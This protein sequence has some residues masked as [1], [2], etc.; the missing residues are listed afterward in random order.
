LL[1]VT[2]ALLDAGSASP[3]GHP[4]VVAA[5]DLPRGHVVGAGDV[6]TQAIT[7]AGGPES[8]DDP[9]GR[10]VT[11]PIFRGEPLVAARLAPDGVEGVAA[12][13]PPGTRGVAVPI[14]LAAPP[15]DV[16]HLVDV[17]LTEAATTPLALELGGGPSAS[18]RVARDALV[19]GVADD[20]IT[21]ALDP[22]DAA[23]VAGGLA[24]GTVTL[25][26]VSPA[27]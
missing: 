16:G 13:L 15:V 5:R 25:A 27:G 20:A 9:V 1:L 4:A 11:E 18:T 8:V 24:T 6:E 22:G 26:V 19:V 21:V 2:D 23:Q 7:P 3:R 10:T 12:L 17:F 14:T